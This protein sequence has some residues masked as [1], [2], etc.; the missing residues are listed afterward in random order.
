[1]SDERIR[2]LER[3]FK[4]TGSVE[5]EAAWL[6]E[7]VRVGD[8]T[9]ERLSLAAY[10]GHKAAR[11]AQ[12]RQSSYQVPESRLRSWF[13][14]LVWAAW[15]S[16]PVVVRAA[17]AAARFSVTDWSKQWQTP[18]DLL[19]ALQAVDAWLDCPCPQHRSRAKEAS[20]KARIAAYDL[21]EEHGIELG[22]APIQSASFAARS[23]AAATEADSSS[24]EGQELPSNSAWAAIYVAAGGDPTVFVHEI[25][26]ARSPEELTSIQ[27]KEPP[28][29][30][31]EREIRREVEQ[32]LIRYALDGLPLT[33]RSANGE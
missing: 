16:K 12:G 28:G 31:R 14:G 24:E 26:A 8:L 4:E 32:A 23:A 3:R 27:A 22:M 11:T 6:K 18:D 9:E 25:L 21:E 19:A 29:A 10:C 5:D 20:D 13:N 15:S 17:N 30:P 1:M 7:R 33:D 2:E